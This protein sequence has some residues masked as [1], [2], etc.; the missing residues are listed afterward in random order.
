M[1]GFEQRSTIYEFAL[2]SEYADENVCASKQRAC[3]ICLKKKKK[4][5]CFASMKRRML[6]VR[7]SKITG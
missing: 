4:F 2:C 6:S 3:S 5:Q 7:G 1:L